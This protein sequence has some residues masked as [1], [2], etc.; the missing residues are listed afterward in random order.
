MSLIEILTAV[1]LIL[2]A[3]LCIALIL[4][5][6]KITKS[7]KQVQNNLNDLSTK[8]VPLISSLSELSNK[9][10]EIS[11]EATSQLDVSK[12]IVGNVKEQVDKFLELG[13]KIRW[14]IEDPVSKILNNLKAISNG[15]NTFINHLKK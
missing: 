10:S 11:N 12:K 3:A 14:G 7:I 6:G 15:V 2:V 8:L 1:V 5:L 9:L 4:Y 13:D